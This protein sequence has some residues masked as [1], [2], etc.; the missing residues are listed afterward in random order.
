MWMGRRRFKLKFES[1][2]I[3]NNII[4]ILIMVFIF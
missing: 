3:I 2:G 1:H 4:I